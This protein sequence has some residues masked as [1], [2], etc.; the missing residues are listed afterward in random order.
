[1]VAPL[2]HAAA[3]REGVGGC[4]FI[5]LFLTRLAGTAALCRAHSRRRPGRWA[6]SP[7][8][9]SLSLPREGLVEEQPGPGLWHEP[10]WAMPAWL[11]AGQQAPGETCPIPN[12]CQETSSF[13]Q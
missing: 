1:M 8:G 4:F 13:R 2:S 3:E 11:T 9:I 12:Q 7:P 5:S 6:L 10:R